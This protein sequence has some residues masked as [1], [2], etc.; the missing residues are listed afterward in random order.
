MRVLI[1][2]AAGFLGSHLCDRFL[3]RRARR[4]SGSTTSSPGTRTTS[5]TSSATIGS[6]SCGTTSRR[7]RTSAGALDGVL[8][9]ASPASPI[10]YL[11]L[12]IQTLKVGSLGTHNALGLAKAKGARFFLASTS[13]VYGDPLVHPQ[14]EELLGQRQPGRAARR[15]R[16]GEALRR[17]D[18]DGVSPLPRGRHAHRPHLQHLRAADAPARRPRRLEL[19][20]PGAE[21]RAAHDLRRR[22][23]DAQLLL[24]R[25]T[26]SRGSTGSSCMATRNPTNIGNP[27]E[28]TVR[29]L[30]EI[31]VELT[32][33]AAPIVYEPLPTDDPKVRQAGH[34][35]ARARCSAG[36]R[37]CPCAT[38]LARTIEYFS[39]TWARR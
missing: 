15:L 17:G 22:L 24:R 1:T 18:H 28:F 34:H 31:V 20:R 4:S 27:D 21:R 12:P 26:R 14:R 30:A 25:P 29:Q 8:H 2:G 37:R 6:S 35:A 13:E 38:G 36:S 9:F 39:G 5:R 11:E 32:G 7:T 16:R 19:H 3:A 23:A 33:L 10:D